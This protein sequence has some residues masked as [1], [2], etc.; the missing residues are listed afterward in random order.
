[1]KRLKKAFNAKTRGIVLNTPLNPSGKVFANKELKLIAD[2]CNEHDTLCFSDEIY[3][4]ILYDGAKHISI[5]SLP[6]MRDRTVTI[7]GFSKTYSITGWRVGYAVSSTEITGAIKVHDFLTV[8]APHPLQIACASALSLPDSYYEKLRS[9]YLKKRNYL[10]SSLESLGFRC[11]RPKGA[12]YIWSDFS[13]VDRRR[14]D[15]EFAKFLVEKVGVALVPG[16]SFFN[17]NGKGRKKVRFTFSKKTETLEKACENL[18][19]LKS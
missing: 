16:S 15:I 19:V 9:D 8:S 4:Y 2:L 11:T 1:M 3:E 18:N 10:L 5:G 6:S 17:Q 13:E 12:Y 14:D 7:S